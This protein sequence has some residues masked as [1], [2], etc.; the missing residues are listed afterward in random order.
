M[1][2]SAHHET[3]IKYAEDLIAPSLE[4][5]REGFA[6]KMRE[7][8]DDEY[9][10]SWI[11]DSY[12]VLPDRDREIWVI[13]VG[14]NGDGKWTRIMDAFW[15]L[16]DDLINLTIWHVDL[17]SLRITKISM[18]QLA[19]YAVARIWNR[20]VQETRR[21]REARKAAEKAAG[22]TAKAIQEAAYRKAALANFEEL[23]RRAR[24]QRRTGV[25]P[26][27]LN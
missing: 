8:T 20:E 19:A 22:K 24:A 10:S 1:G 3:L 15:A 9:R 13:E 6:K 25:I 21:E 2:V 12:V 5:K 23:R 14:G 4:W 18:G 11:P 27:D 7:F 26:T 16:D 17:D